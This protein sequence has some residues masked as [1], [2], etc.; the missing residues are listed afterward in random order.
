MRFHF[1]HYTGYKPGINPNRMPN[2]LNI[3]LQTPYT[4]LNIK[5]WQNDMQTASLFDMW[6]LS[7]DVNSLHAMQT[8]IKSIAEKIKIWNM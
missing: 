6:V 8:K 4:Y 5:V 2:P 7:F 1:V 3:C